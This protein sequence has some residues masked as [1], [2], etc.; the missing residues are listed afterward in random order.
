VSAARK[1]CQVF[2]AAALLAGALSLSAA[3]VLA[4]LQVASPATATSAAPAQKLKLD[5]LPNFG[6][7]TPTLYRGGQPAAAG[8]QQLKTLGIEIVVNL[9]EAS[10]GTAAERAR[11]AALGMRYVSLPWRP[12]A[13]P[14][15]SQVA[16][17][18]KLVRDNAS[19][20]VFVHCRRG[21]ERTGV[22]IAAY[23][24]AFKRWTPEQA[25]AEMEAFGFHGFWFRAMK[26]YVANFPRELATHPEL[27]ALQPAPAH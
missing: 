5:G 23:R 14:D 26:K 21:A 20:K 3:H 17:F 9:R 7:V 22:M 18:L 4:A 6:R 12:G 11:V 19:K 24:I 8:Y 16:E 15:S 13:R 2:F 1:R 25:L 10:E 27:R